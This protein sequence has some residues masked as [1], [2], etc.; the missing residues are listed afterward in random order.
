MRPSDPEELKEYRQMKTHL[1]FDE[2]FWMIRSPSDDSSDWP[3]GISRHTVLGKWHQVKLEM[4][5]HL[6]QS[7]NRVELTCESEVPF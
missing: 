5:D 4:W 6:Q 7:K 3:K 2:V 1:T